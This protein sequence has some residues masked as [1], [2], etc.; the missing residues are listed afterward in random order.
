MANQRPSGLSSAV[1]SLLG[2][3]IPL[4]VFL[5][6]TPYLVAR[7][8]TAQYGI[9]MLVMSLTAILGSLDFGLAAGGVREIGGA[10][11]RGENERLVRLL[12]EYLSLFALVGLVVFGALV[13]F[14]SQVSTLLAMDEV[15]SK[16]EA[17]R[18]VFLMAVSLLFYLLTAWA[19]LLP[20]TMERYP[21]IALIQVV[22]N[23]AAWGGAVALLALNP[24]HGLLLVVA[25]TTFLSGFVCF[26]FLIFSRLLLP[27][28]SCCPAATFRETPGT[29][30]YSL[31][32]SVGQLT[33]AFTYHADK[34]LIAYFL[35]PEPVAYYAVA[36]TVASKLLSV[37]AAMA[38]FAFPRAVA[39]SAGADHS[40][41][42]S[43]YARVSRYQLLVLA[44]LLAPAVILAEPLLTLWLGPAFASQATP[45]LQILCF[46]YFLAVLSV[47]PS[48]V[49]N[50]LGNARI[51]AFFATAATVINIGGCIILLPIFGVVGAAVASL[52]GMAQAIVYAGALEAHLGLGWFTARRSFYLA[53]SGIVTGQ[54]LALYAARLLVEGWASLLLVGAGGY[55]LFYLAWRVFGLLS[56]EDKRVLGELSGLWQRKFLN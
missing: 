24:G 19:S 29:F 44:P 49:F 18:V 20:R 52:L 50:G 5:L 38:N 53:V 41:L 9:L 27:G 56:P 30:G 26:A 34:V 14:A 43:F 28:F 1:A 45:L 46:G 23:I 11:A 15:L 47:V 31:Y 48:Q 55:A 25:W 7:L 51:G 54:F 4:V 37:G 8:G 17:T 2:L 22:S 12:R 40:A 39:L 33:A 21:A 35:G 6:T 10:L 16:E 3:A 36:T 42:K 13:L 32:A